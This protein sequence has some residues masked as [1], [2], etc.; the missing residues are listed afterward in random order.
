MRKTTFIWVRLEDT[1][2]VVENNCL[3]KCTDNEG[4]NPV[5]VILKYDTLVNFLKELWWQWIYSF[6]VEKMWIKQVVYVIQFFSGFFK[7]AKNSFS[8]SQICTCSKCWT[9]APQYFNTCFDVGKG[10]LRLVGLSTS[11]FTKSISLQKT[12]GKLNNLCFI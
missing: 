9:R 2:L 10:W 4:K 1:D 11:S 12:L 5:E 8:V 6:F 7:V 3:W